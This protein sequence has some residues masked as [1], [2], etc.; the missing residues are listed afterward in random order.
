MHVLSETAL[1]PKAPS[2]LLDDLGQRAGVGFGS[3]H[4]FTTTCRTRAESGPPRALPGWR[5]RL[6]GALAGL[7]AAVVCLASTAGSSAA[8]PPAGAAQQLADK[9]APIVMVRSQDNGLCDSSEE[10][11]APPTAVES[12]LDDPKVRLLLHESGGTRLVKRAPGVADLAGLGAG[13]Y[14]DL[15]G[16]P[17][18]PGCKFAKDFAALKR[19]GDAPAVTYAHI[20]RQPGHSGFALQYWFFYYF[21]QFND[22]HEG[23]WEGMQIAFGVATPD[24]ALTGSP[25]EMV[26]FQHSGGEHAGWDDPKVE[27]QGTHPVVYSA[28]GSHATFYGSALYLGNGQ[29]GS[30]VGCDNTT[31]P[32]TAVRPRAVLLPDEPPARGRFAWLDFTGRWGQREA[33]FNNGPAGPSTKTVWREPF[34]WMDGTRSASPTVPGGALVGP[35]VATAFCGAVAQVTG[36]LNLAASTSLGALGVAVGLLLLIL[37][38]ACLTRWRPSAVEPMRQARGLGQLLLTAAR[39]YRRHAATLLLIA[40]ASLAILGAVNGIELL[41][42]RALGVQAS[43]FSFAGAG[44][45]IEIS[46]SAGIGRALA[47]P[48]A[49]AAVIAFMRDLERGPKASFATSWIEVWR[50]LWRLVAVELL[51]TLL[52]VLLMITIIGIPYGLK[53]YVDW[54]FAQQEVLFEDRSIREALHRSTDRVRRHWWHTAAVAITFWVLAQIPGPVL[55]FALLFTTLPVTTV[56]LVGSAIF[57]LMIPYVGVGRTLLYLDLAARKETEAVA[58]RP[59]IA[60]AP[61]T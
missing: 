16:D 57:F 20:A 14:L 23:D 27:K 61:A 17:L 37:V 42:R 50:R 25:T 2:D 13:Y 4:G 46:T 21:N 10:Q 24:Q 5:R 47:T 48:V 39:L 40:L 11:Y 6:A 54:Q 41:I 45:G 28:A 59:V 9:Y 55:G 12:V 49:S 1:E 32:V 18:N 15:P 30:G 44:S 36:F 35:S 38:P 7:L 22:L 34:T 43:S 3:D 33:G 26:L 52:V 19:A 8:T 29:G 56:N 51:A 53:K 58:A 60:P 31:K